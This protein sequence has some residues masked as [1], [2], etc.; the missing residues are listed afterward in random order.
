MISG[1]PRA[2]YQPFY[3]QVVSVQLFVQPSNSIASSTAESVFAPRVTPPCYVFIVARQERHGAELRDY[4]RKLLQAQP[5][6]K[7][8]RELL[9]LRRIQVR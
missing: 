3:S 2:R 5:R 6:P 1:V 9:D 4:Q 8:S 7:F